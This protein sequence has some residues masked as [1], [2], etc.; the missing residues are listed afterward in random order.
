[1]I[2]KII[3]QIWEGRTEYLRDS[4]KLLGETWK[5]HHP[6]WKYEFWEENRLDDFVYDYF[7][8]IVDIYFGIQC[9][10][11]AC[12]PLPGPLPNG[13]DVCRF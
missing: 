11:L 6:D 12:N 5:E 7:S 9:A 8:E 4:Y 2:P 3:H 10:T 1:M 13:R